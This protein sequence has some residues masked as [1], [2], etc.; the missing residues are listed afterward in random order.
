MLTSFRRILKAGWQNFCRQGSLTFVTVFMMVVTISLVTGLFIFQ[1]TAHFLVGE[2]QN[3]ADISVYFKEGT[4]PD[5]I[6]KVQD[7]LS[8]Q[9][10]SEISDIK[11]IS[12]QEAYKNFIDKHQQDPNYMEALEVVEINPFLSHLNI[13]A[14]QMSQYEAISQFFNKESAKDIVEKVDYYSRKPV[15]E[16]LFS[17]AANINILGIIITIILGL[18]AILVT[19]NTV[20]LAIFSQKSEIGIM[21]LVGA[22]N[23][24]IQGGFLFQ[25]ILCGFLAAIITFILFYGVLR[26]LSPSLKNLLAEINVYH[27]FYG[28]LLVIFL[29][30]ALTGIGLGAISSFIAVKKYLKV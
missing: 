22:K 4:P 10:P 11:Y 18:A 23:G 19:F 28:H 3:K 20:R 30:Q 17:L 8:K 26:F 21:R 27:F 14:K 24:F 29:L 5:D 1:R 2:L 9:F 7:E 13:R 12:S 25:G 16:Q 15:I 6:F